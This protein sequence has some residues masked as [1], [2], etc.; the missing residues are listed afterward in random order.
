M[1]R[2]TRTVGLALSALLGMSLM[3]TPASAQDNLIDVQILT[4]N[5][6][7][8][9]I[10][11][12]SG[13]DAALA[14]FDGEVGGAAYLAALI[15]ARRE[16]FT[17]AGGDP[18][19]SALFSVGDNI[20]ASPFE[21]S[22]F[23]DEPT[24]EV[25]NALGVEASPVGNHEFDRG[26]DELRRI[27]NGG[28]TGT[29]GQD[30]CFRNG[31][32]AGANFPYLAAN[33]VNEAGEP[34]LDPY[35]IREV[36][37]PN[38]P[39]RI[40][41]IGVVTRETV[42]IVMPSGIEGLTFE[43]EARTINRYAAVLQEQGV[44]A[45]IALIHEGA[46]EEPG[47]STYNG[48]DG[49][50]QGPGGEINARVSSS[51][52]LLVQAHT[53]QAY[54]CELEDPDGNRRLLTQASSYGKVLTDIRFQ[55]SPSTGDIER[56]SVNATNYATD[57]ASLTPDQ[58]I[59]AIVDYWM[60]Q[61]DEMRNVVV[62][63]ITGPITRARNSAGAEDRGAESSLGNLVADAQLWATRDQ[64]AQIAFMNPGGLR[65]DISYDPPGGSGSDD[66][67]YGELFNVQPFGNTVNTITLTGAQ[68]RQVLE[69]QW[70]I[71]SDGSERKLHLGV[72]AG[73]HYVYDPTRPIGDRVD[74]R[75]ITL[76]GEVIDPE[77]EYRVTANSFLTEGGDGFTALAEG[78]DLVTGP[79]DIESFVEFFRQNSPVSPPP[80][81]RTEEG[82]F[83]SDPQAP[84]ADLG[85]VSSRVT[86][87]RV[88]E[89]G[90]FEAVVG[91]AGPEQATGQTTVTVEISGPVSLVAPSEADDESDDADRNAG[92]VARASSGSTLE[93]QEPAE[94]VRVSEW[95]IRGNRASLTITDLPAGTQ[96]KITLPFLLDE[97]AEVGDD[98]AITATIIPPTGI[99]DP[100]TENNT[101]TYTGEVTDNVSPSPSASA[102]SP[103]GAGGGLPRTGSSLLT[104]FGTALAL[105]L[106]GGGFLLMSRRRRAQA[107][108]VGA[109]ASVAD[110]DGDSETS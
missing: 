63:Q 65:S 36:D 105:L 16:A 48:C 70:Q 55:I 104:L 57:R 54:I 74:P 67:T 59:Q 88:G 10:N 97:D 96:V 23:R 108:T 4:F 50:L 102:S 90:T 33:V 60:D 56:D 27:Q 101:V 85:F 94:G 49:A 76:N 89:T 42:G 37:G 81:N 14:G 95:T 87:T 62:G 83:L 80:T 58:E 51:V 1:R 6:F 66:V 52:D 32:Y 106:L 78:T 41:V 17:N 107:A 26:Q 38:G 71:Q 73:F 21:S 47:D 24:I 8:G 99:T 20:G 45:I 72:S 34:I 110:R 12:G 91:N 9:R 103:P 86:P 75:Q 84:R 5:D 82:E 28:C 2:W 68:I 18:D 7:H 53:H 61:A 100:R 79:V 43:D 19:N 3:G 31:S 93:E 30:S 98:V 39:V 40:G 109:D 44:Q 11:A 69:Q 29:P 64:G 77:A 13:S 46:T 35:F 25:L 15:D 22:V 92:L